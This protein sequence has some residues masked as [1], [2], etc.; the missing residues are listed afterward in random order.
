MAGVGGAGG[1]KG[2]GGASR[3][4][5]SR[6]GAKTGGAKSSKAGKSASAAKTGAKADAAKAKATQDAAKTKAAAEV[7]SELAKDKVASDKTQVQAEKSVTAAS[8]AQAEQQ[9]R[10]ENVNKAVTDARAADP[11]TQAADK[12]GVVD[13]VSKVVDGVTGGNPTSKGVGAIAST[14]S[15]GIATGQHTANAIDAATKGD[16]TKAL[17][18]GGQ[19][20]VSGVQTLAAAAQTPFAKAVKIGARFA[21]PAAA[22][23]AAVDTAQF[24]DSLSKAVNE[25]GVSNWAKAAWDGTKA[26][27]STASMVPAAGAIPGAIAG[28]MDLGEMASNAIG[29]WWNG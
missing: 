10:Q 22:L 8:N 9:Q 1:S 27:L 12:S 7:K 21:G 29:S 13:K 15:N 25:G 5:A 28:A 2:G 24:S 4:S 16:T 19:A 26:G 3:S 17:N 14:I 20:V 11:I 18:E 6:G 23:S